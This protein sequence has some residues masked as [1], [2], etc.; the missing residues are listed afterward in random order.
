MKTDGGAP[1]H[2]SGKHL[3]ASAR[4]KEVLAARKPLFQIPSH[5]LM[6]SLMMAPVAAACK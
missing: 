2:S 5:V 1:N 4:F 6:F 3:L